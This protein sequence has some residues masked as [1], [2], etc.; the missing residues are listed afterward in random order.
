MRLEPATDS[1]EVERMSDER[2]HEIKI[3]KTQNGFILMPAVPDFCPMVIE[4]WQVA[5]SVDEIADLVRI[6]A[7][8]VKK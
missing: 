7:E 4:S 5:R 1:Q 2:C 3:Q 8:A 6:W